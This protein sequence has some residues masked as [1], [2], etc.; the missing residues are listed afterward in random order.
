M[1]HTLTV[2]HADPGIDAIAR[3]TGQPVRSFV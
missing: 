2:L 3:I 1:N